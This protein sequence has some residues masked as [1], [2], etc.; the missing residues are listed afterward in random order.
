MSLNIA[1]EVAALERMTGTKVCTTGDL[2]SAPKPIRRTGSTAT[3][4]TSGYSGRQHRSTSTKF[5]RSEC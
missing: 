5:S 2:R 3:N 4:L 1:K